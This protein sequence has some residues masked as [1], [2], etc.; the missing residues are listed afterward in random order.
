MT[1]WRNS[2]IGTK[3]LTA[4]L[5]LILLSIVLVSSI[6][7]IIAQRELE[8]QAFNK[9]IATREIKAA[10]IENHFSQI[11][12]QI[13]TFSEKQMVISA[14]KDFA[15]ASKAIFEERNLTPE[16]EAALQ[17]RVVE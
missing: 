5:P 1:I 6:S 15:T 17:T 7:I 16:A 4:L 11:R 12:H 3:V 13:E 8:K 9:L 14:M 10:E 2:N